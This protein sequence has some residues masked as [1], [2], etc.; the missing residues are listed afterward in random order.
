MGHSG[1]G[2]QARGKVSR[3]WPFYGSLKKNVIIQFEQV[4][5]RIKQ[6]LKSNKIL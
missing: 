1:E 2:F 3:K 4:L 6:Y 5:F